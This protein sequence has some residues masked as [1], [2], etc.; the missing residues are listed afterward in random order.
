MLGT[1]SNISQTLR[2]GM[3]TTS[4]LARLP[5]QQQHFQPLG[6]GTVTTRSLAH[7][8]DQNVARTWDTVAG[9]PS[10]YSTCPSMSGGG[11]EIEVPARHDNNDIAIGATVRTWCVG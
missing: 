5:F 10:G 6:H 11:M 9:V 1:T 7:K 8:S 3:V 2:H 4:S